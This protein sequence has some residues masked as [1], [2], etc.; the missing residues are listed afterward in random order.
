M[1]ILGL[2]EC[3]NAFSRNK[4]RIIC[5]S[6]MLGAFQSTASAYQKRS[7]RGYYHRKKCNTFYY[8]R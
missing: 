6:Y 1:A 3:I 5:L 4:R 2:S 7:T 8:I